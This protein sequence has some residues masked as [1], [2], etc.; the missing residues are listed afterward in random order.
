MT[1]MANIGDALGRAAANALRQVIG[2]AIGAC[3][4]GYFGYY[5]VHGDRGLTALRHL[6]GEIREA[7]LRLDEVKAERERMERRAQLMRTDNLDLDM[8]EERAR[9]LLNLTHPR[10]VVVTVPRLP[11]LEEDA[12]MVRSR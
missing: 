6:Q 4:V 11:P 3:I 10:D 5:A 9:G 12:P 2:P 1:I 8:L 7:E